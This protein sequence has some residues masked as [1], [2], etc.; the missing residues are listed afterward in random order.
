MLLPSENHEQLLLEKMNHVPQKYEYSATLKSDTLLN[1]QSMRQYAECCSGL[2]SPPSNLDGH[3]NQQ[4]DSKQSCK[5]FRHM[6]E[7]TSNWNKTKLIHRTDNCGQH[8]YASDNV[9]MKIHRTLM[10]TRIVDFT[11]M[12]KESISKPRVR[13]ITIRLPPTLTYTHHCIAKS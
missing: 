8:L 5:S 11:Y 4:L 2:Q 12:C 6:P 7:S 13:R 3:H 9:M 10:P 1:I